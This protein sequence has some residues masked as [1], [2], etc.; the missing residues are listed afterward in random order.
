[1]GDQR[2]DP[3]PRHLGIREGEVPHPAVGFSGVYS[4]SKLGRERGRFL[5]AFSRAG[6]IS[7]QLTFKEMFKTSQH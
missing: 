2:R 5:S 6:G 4:P 7:A 1:M 3:L